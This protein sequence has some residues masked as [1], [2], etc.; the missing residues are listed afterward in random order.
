MCP[1]HV[2]VNGRGRVCLYDCMCVCVCSFV[3]HFLFVSVKNYLIHV[4]F[5]ID[6]F[7]LPSI[8]SVMLCRH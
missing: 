3:K 6:P 1:F 2:E 5:S 7:I 4:C 8:H